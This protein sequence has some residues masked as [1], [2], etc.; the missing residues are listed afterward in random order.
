MKDETWFLG[1][2]SFSFYK[3]STFLSQEEHQADSAEPSLRDAPHDVTVTLKGI[4]SLLLLLAMIWTASSKAVR[5]SFGKANINIYLMT[6]MILLSN[7][8]EIY[9]DIT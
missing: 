7:Y 5:Q 2:Y 1:R 3:K 8:N 4:V 6:S 9:D